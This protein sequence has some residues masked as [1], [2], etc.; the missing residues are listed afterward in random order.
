M[1][2]HAGHIEFPGGF[3]VI[4]KEM[5]E[6][7]LDLDTS[8]KVQQFKEEVAALAGTWAWCR[9]HSVEILWPGL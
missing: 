1:P 7:E 9:S 6:F 2:V 8:E 5:Q 3:A 4:V